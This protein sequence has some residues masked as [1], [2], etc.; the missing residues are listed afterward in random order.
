MDVPLLVVQYFVTLA[1]G[2]LFDRSY[3]ACYNRDLKSSIE[4]QFI[5]IVPYRLLLV[6]S[7]ITAV[8]RLVKLTKSS[9]HA[10]SQEMYLNTVIVS[11]LKNL[12]S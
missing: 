10:L 5:T 6:S 4:L 12:F 1:V 7:P 9:F 2:F 3:L 11:H 8:F